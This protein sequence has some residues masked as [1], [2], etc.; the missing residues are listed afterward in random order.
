MRGLGGENRG[1]APSAVRALSSSVVW[2]ESALLGA[3]G[4]ALSTLWDLWRMLKRWR[5][6]GV[7][8]PELQV[9]WRL[10]TVASELNRAVLGALLA[11]VTTVGNI[12]CGP[13]P[14]VLAGF[15]AVFIC[16]RLGQLRS[17]PIILD[18]TP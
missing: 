12:I 13:W 8:P 10:A 14:A 4:S 2:V 3:A 18:S 16:E 9:G 7:V 1:W 17:H 5:G 6:T 11:A 15:M